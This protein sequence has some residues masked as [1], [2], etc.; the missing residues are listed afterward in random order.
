M[1][2]TADLSSA[3]VMQT[4]GGGGG[5]AS[6]IVH[7]A[8]ITTGMVPTVAP[9]MASSGIHPVSSAPAPAPVAVAFGANGGIGLDGGSVN[10][11]FSGGSGSTGDHALGLLIQSIGAGGGETTVGGNLAANVT[12][13]GS[14]NAAGNGGALTIVN[15]SAV[16]TEGKG[17]HGIV[18][19]SIG[20]GGGAVFGAGPGTTGGGWI[21]TLFA[22]TAGGSGHGGAIRLDLGSGVVAT[23][24]GATAIF[25]Q[26]L[27]STGAGDITVNA[28]GTVRGNAAGLGLDGGVSN[29]VTVTGSV[30][31]VSGL[32]IS[33]TTGN[34]AIIN[35]GVII[36]NVDLGTGANSINNRQGGTFIAFNTID[37]YDPPSPA[38]LPAA[39]GALFSNAGEFQMGL[40]APQ[41]PVDIGHGVAFDTTDAIGDPK[42]N[43]LY[44]ARV[45]N[46][47][48]LDGNFVQ[49]PTGHMAF[50][51][52]FG[53]YASDRVNVTGSAE[54][55][56]R[57][58]VTLM[59]LANSDP[60]TLFSA[61]RGGT[62]KGL[63]I[64]DT[65]A[66]D[67]RV[68]SGAPGIQLAFSTNF[69][70]DFLNRNGR[71]LGHHMD[72][73]IALGG[74]DGIGRTM[75]WLGNLKAGQEDVYSAL[76]AELSPE[77]FVAPLL[78]LDASSDRFNRDLFGCAT[79]VDTANQS[80]T[81]GHVEN[82]SLRRSQ[83]S[84]SFDASSEGTSLSTGFARPLNDLWSVTVAV[85]YDRISALTGATGR[86]R[87]DG[88]SLQLGMGFRRV[89]ANGSDVALSL[90]SGWQDIDT[91]RMVYVFDP[92]VG[93]SNP[94]ATV[95][96]AALKWGKTYR[97][98]HLYVRPILNVALTTLQQKAFQEQGLE[99]NGVAGLNHTQ[100]IAT[101]GPEL[102][103][104]YVSSPSS[105][106]VTKL[107]FDVAHS[108]RDTS[109]IAMPYRLI[110]ANPA[111][112]TALVGTVVGRGLDHVGITFESFKVNS[113]ASLRLNYSQDSSAKL[114]TSSLGMTLRMK[115]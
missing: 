24:A 29:V 96:K 45:T 12:L 3:I 91:R 101:S 27:G 108:V 95:L 63:Q 39:P 26:S 49:T 1:T 50:D 58:T 92:L 43:L 10:T 94:Q 60:V 99:G 89:M 77:P 83:D 31:A 105:G 6:I 51:V 86:A 85:G 38:A 62:D 84:E 70:Q 53:P 93:I 4:I 106:Y 69:A 73:A 110:G 9:I 46:T 2:T 55:A 81:W 107:E 61:A 97:G 8:G 48:A 37:L 56:G 64:D 57:G 71:A 16:E 32:A 104:G 75:A 28:G 33:G 30:S 23:G 13:G 115:F 66:M 114:R 112:D 18:L 82:D 25:A 90:S 68:L 11:T 19:Q 113:R 102:A 100:T 34:D 76:F 21:D 109:R 54:V 59:W 36:G 42:T 20:G 17:S 22:G 14:G 35:D 40:S 67:Y 5:A 98:E 103:W 47:V 74:S 111:S 52:A 44:G 87:S 65:I 78:E 88:Q 72:S 15:T 79:A 80:C 7:G 41:R